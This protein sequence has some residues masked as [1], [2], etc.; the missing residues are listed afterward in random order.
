M[1]QLQGNQASAL[2]DFRISGVGFRVYS[3]GFG[4]KDLGFRV[5]DLG[6]SVVSGLGFR[7]S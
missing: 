3:L 6:F 2:T 5:K 7:V 1:V 4:V